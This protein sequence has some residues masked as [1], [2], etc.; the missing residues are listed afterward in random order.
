VDRN[1]NAPTIFDPA[2]SGRF[3]LD[4]P[5]APWTDLGWCTGFRRGS[6][7]ANTGIVA[8]RT[9]APAMTSTQARINAE[10]T[11]ELEFATWGKLQLAL[12]CGSQQMNLLAVQTASTP[13]RSGGAAAAPIALQP[14]STATSL[15]AGSFASQFNAGD[16]IAVD[17]DYTGQTG[18]VGSGISGAYIRA[19]ADTGGDVDY[20]RRV[21][22]NVGRI[23]GISESALQLD[24]PLLAGAPISGMKVSRIAGFVD[25]EGGT[26]FQQWSGL[27]VMDGEQGDRVIFYYP[28]LE[29]MRGAAETSVTLAG[30]LERIRLAG[31]FRALPMRDPADGEMVLCFRSYLPA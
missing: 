7:A 25:R 8:L 28:R 26:F 18:F 17:D 29:A 23:V 9:G 16:L 6:D 11:V 10:A 15:N 22:L 27:F 3:P 14:G 19:A 13:G 24:A 31:A 5:P 4:A 30:T 2:Q 1:T 20:I 12:T 21:S